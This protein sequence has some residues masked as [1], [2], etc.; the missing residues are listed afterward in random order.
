[1]ERVQLKDGS[2]EDV[3]QEDLEATA[4][5]W[6]RLIEHWK[7]GKDQIPCTPD[8]ELSYRTT[9]EAILKKEN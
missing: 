2:F 4:E 8:P 9:V 7:E 3:S 5:F 6:D 1:V